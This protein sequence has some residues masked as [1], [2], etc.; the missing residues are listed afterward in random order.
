MLAALHTGDFGSTEFNLLSVDTYKLDGF[1]SVV[2]PSDF[3][4]SIGC[5]STHRASR[6][7]AIGGRGTLMLSVSFPTDRK[8]VKDRVLPLNG[9]A[10]MLDLRI[11]IDGFK[12]RPMIIDL[13]DH[14]VRLIAQL[15]GNMHCDTK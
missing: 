12:R 13:I 11:K 7:P 9:R 4:V 5:L 15:R 6:P 14:V 3:S 8:A 10:R 2:L 1:A